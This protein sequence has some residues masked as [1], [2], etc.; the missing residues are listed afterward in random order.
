M[1]RQ[2]TWQKFINSVVVAGLEMW[3]PRVISKPGISQASSAGRSGCLQTGQCRRP[4]L[5]FLCE[6]SPRDSGQFVGQGHGND[7]VAGTT[8][9]FS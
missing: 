4:V 1:N 7:V 8:C 5:F 9:E 2:Q 3:K 6:H